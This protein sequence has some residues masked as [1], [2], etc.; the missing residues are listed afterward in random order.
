MNAIKIRENYMQIKMFLHTF[1]CCLFNFSQYVFKESKLFTW[2]DACLIFK[3][4]HQKANY[5]S[6]MMLD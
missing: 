4:T 2:D 3:L 6:W 1:P 5:L